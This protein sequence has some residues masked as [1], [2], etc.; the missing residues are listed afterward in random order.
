MMY[1]NIFTNLNN[2][3]NEFLIILTLNISI[4]LLILCIKY[5]KY[6]YYIFI[7]YYVFIYIILSIL[8]TIIFLI[9]KCYMGI[10][11]FDKYLYIDK[12][13]E[14]STLYFVLFHVVYYMILGFLFEFRGWKSSII[15]TIIVEFLI[16]YIQKCNYKTINIESGIYSIIIGLT[17]YFTGSILRFLLHYYIKFYI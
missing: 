12:N 11:Y 17:S 2:E 9:A 6:I 3:I 14:N 15:Q 5:Y 7:N 16:A 1:I 10:N 13:N 4:L 8:F